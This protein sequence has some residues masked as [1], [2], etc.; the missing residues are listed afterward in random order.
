MHV[1]SA[2]QL[3]SAPDATRER[4]FETIVPPS[5]GLRRVSDEIVAHV[6][7][8]TEADA[9]MVIKQEWPEAEEWRFNNETTQEP[10]G[11]RFPL[12]DWMVERYEQENT[13]E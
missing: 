9:E 5:P 11:D 7:A 13:N 8:Q 12:S 2:W 3:H 1:N 10:P 4:D 6:R